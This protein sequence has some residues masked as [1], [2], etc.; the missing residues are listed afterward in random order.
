MLQ[1]VFLDLDDTILDFHT[2]E[3]LAI[4]EALRTFGTVADDAVLRRYSEI[5][6]SFWERLERREIKREEVLLGR[7]RQ[8]L[9]EIGCGASAEEMQTC[10]ESHL[11]HQGIFLPGAKELLDTLYG[12]YRLYLASNGNSRVQAGRIAVTGIRR[13]FDDIFVSQELGADKPSAEFFARAFARIGDVERDRTVMVGDSLT[14]DILG[15]KN[16]GIR[17]VWFCPK[18][19]PQRDGISPDFVIR[20]LDELPSL[21]KTL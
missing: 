11:E 18:E 8:F 2:A 5:N 20:S 13:Y 16:A 9:S 7:F 17:T 12:K 4:S 3:R 10:Y 21:L 1:N 19:K 14:S 6:K 15:G